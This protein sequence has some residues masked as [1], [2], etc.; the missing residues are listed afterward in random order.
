MPRELEP[1]VSVL[2]GRA[3]RRPRHASQD[4]LRAYR[5]AADSPDRPAAA[6][7]RLREIALR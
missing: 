1:T 7:G 2:T 6:Q 5:A 3:G 4:A